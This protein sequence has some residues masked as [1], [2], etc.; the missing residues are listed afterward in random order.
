[1]NLYHWSPVKD[2]D[3]LEGQTFDHIRATRKK[4]YFVDERREEEKKIRDAF[5]IKDD[6]RSF[7]NVVLDDYH[8]FPKTQK[9]I[10]KYK[11]PLQGVSLDD[12]YFDYVN[13]DDASRNYQGG[14]GKP[15]L[16]KAIK[17]WNE[18]KS[19]KPFD[20][21]GYK[22]YP[23]I[24]GY[25][26]GRITPV[27]EKSKEKE[28]MKKSEFIKQARFLNSARGASSFFRNRAAQD[29]RAW[30]KATRAA[31]VKPKAFNAGIKELDDVL[32]Q[33]GIAG[34]NFKWGLPLEG[35]PAP[36][37]LPIPAV[38]SSAAPGMRTAKGRVLNS[39][40][41]FSMMDDV[42][43]ARAA[44][45]QGLKA[46]YTVPLSGSSSP[47]AA[48]VSGSAPAAAASS[49]AD[50][51]ASPGFRKKFSDWFN[52]RSRMQKLG[53]VGGAGFAGGWIPGRLSGYS[54]GDQDGLERGLTQGGQIGFD[55]A[56][57][58]AR[59]T[60]FFSRMMGR[61][62]F[63]PSS[64]MQQLQQFAGSDDAYSGR[65]TGVINRMWGV[66]GVGR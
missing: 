23:R 18:A 15:Y 4:D 22:I 5:G 59:N 21:E 8:K 54:L 31:G 27:R 36:K 37:D 33:Q 29:L 16:E 49:A 28:K 1:M 12:I 50:D 9:G 7:L 62:Q 26:R 17:T 64:A 40:T 3:Y 57:G 63:D 53:L 47:A 6:S 19:H 46:K 41:P 34:K 32:R 55:T 56:M 61:Y 44:Q 13:D 38:A 2:L 65:Q 11:I 24:E 51:I 60:P 30:R 20:Y 35:L 48:S 39:Y 25:V 52:E 45:M 14:V 10:Q 43:G 66:P 58:Q 42:N